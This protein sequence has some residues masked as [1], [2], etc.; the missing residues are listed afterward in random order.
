MLAMVDKH[1]DKKWYQLN[2][3]D[4]SMLKYVY[5]GLKLEDMLELQSL[6]NLSKVVYKN[7]TN[8]LTA[9]RRFNTMTK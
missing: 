4:I 8:A 1:A 9:E 2:Y 5:A 7:R 6:P 3:K